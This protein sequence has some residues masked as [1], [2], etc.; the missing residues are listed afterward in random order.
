M[1]TVIGLAA[2]V[3]VGMIT[4]YYCSMGK[5]PV[6]SIVEQSKTGTATNIIAGSASAW[7]PRAWPIVVIAPA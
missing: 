6:N 2:G 5:R 7:S 4:S 3:A 1:A